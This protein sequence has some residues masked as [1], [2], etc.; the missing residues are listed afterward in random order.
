M[1]NIDSIMFVE[2]PPEFEYRSGLFH[3]RQRVSPNCVLERV[4]RPHV[5]FRA[6]Q[7]AAQA[8][9]DYHNAEGGEADPTGVIQFPRTG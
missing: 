2:E 8:I 1:R 9:Q 5:M 4:M 7:R 6:F 3:I